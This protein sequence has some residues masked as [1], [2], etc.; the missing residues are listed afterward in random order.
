M[1]PRRERQRIKLK[2]NARISNESDYM[3]T[4]DPKTP[5][6]DDHLNIGLQTQI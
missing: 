1:T 3:M 4:L 2:T 6:V 5:V